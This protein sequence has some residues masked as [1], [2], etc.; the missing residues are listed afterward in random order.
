MSD[1]GS[2]G[3]NPTAYMTGTKCGAL[4]DYAHAPEISNCKDAVGRYITVAHDPAEGGTSGGAIITICEAEI[5]GSMAGTPSWPSAAQG[6]RLTQ[7]PLPPPPAVSVASTQPGYRNLLTSVPHGNC[8]FDPCVQQGTC[9]I[10]T[11][12]VGGGGVSG[13]NGLRRCGATSSST[14]GWGG[15]PDR[16]VDKNSDTDW[17]RSSC[18]HTDAGDVAGQSNGQ[19]GAWWQVT[20]LLIHSCGS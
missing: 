8:H 5:F 4:S 10:Q 20:P 3:Q 13:K 7:P 2:T 18:S 12:S 19:A 11:N 6:T 17:R 16:V 9:S 15:E 1:T 14:V